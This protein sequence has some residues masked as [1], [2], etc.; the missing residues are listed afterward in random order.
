MLSQR[1]EAKLRAR[2]E[3][4][5]E[6]RQ[7]AHQAMVSVVE[8]IESAR[9]QLEKLDNQQYRAMDSIQ[10]AFPKE[11][12]WENVDLYH[13][14]DEL[15]AEQISSDMLRDFIDEPTVFDSPSVDEM[16]GDILSRV[17]DIEEER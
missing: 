5:L 8:H 11:V 16:L 17:E 4:Y 2:I 12:S 15:G 7:M 6:L 1:E 10:D 13:V 3:R 9:E 14:L